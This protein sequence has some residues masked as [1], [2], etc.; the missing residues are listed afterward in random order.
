MIVKNAESTIERCLESVKGLVDEIVVVDTGSNDNTI[1]IVEKY[2]N[3]LLYKFNWCEDFSEARN[4]SIDKTS[5]D[6][7]LVLDSDEY[8]VDG[9]RK[10]LELIMEQK[11]IGR[12]LI[13][14]NFNKDNQIYI[15]NEYVSRFFP[16]EVKYVGII[17]EQLNSSIPNVKMNLTVKHDGYFE[18]NKSKRNI[19]LLV[20]A[21]KENPT[22]SYYFY[23]LG[24]ELRISGRFE[25]AY[26]FLKKSYD[27]T[28]SMVPYY[29]ELVVEL[30]NSGKES[31]KEELLRVIDRNEEILGNSSDFHFAKSMFYMDYCIKYQYKAESLISEIEKGFLICLELNDKV[32]VETVQGTSSYLSQYNL[33]VFYEVTGNISNA[34][35][36]YRLASN[37]GYQLATNRFKLLN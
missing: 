20:K 36:Y 3:I 9:T 11:L 15:S 32:H 10:D 24:K 27:N 16:R 18:T 1:T 29:N 34:I 25:E 14:S 26:L 31:G 35:K 12:M 17:H 22:D 28:N 4:Y 6:Y 19:P 37:Q 13:C 21:I 7:V 33:G 2:P 23:Q 5:G 30:I 8:I